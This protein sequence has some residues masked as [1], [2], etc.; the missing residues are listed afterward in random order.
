[1][2]KMYQKYAMTVTL[3][4]AM[5]FAL[6]ACGTSSASVVDSDAGD[7]AETNSIL[8]ENEQKVVMGEIA[9]IIGN[10]VTLKVVEMPQRQ[11]P[12]G[13]PEGEAPGNFGDMTEEE[14]QAMREQMGGDRQGGNF[15]DMTEEERQAMREQMGE[16]M[17]GRPGG[18]FADMTEEE[19]QA[20]IQEMFPD[21]VPEG[22]Q[23][24]E[25]DRFGQNYTG[26]ELD[27]IIPVGAPIL[28]ASFSFEGSEEAEIKLENLKA[29]DML[30]VTYASDDKTVEKVVRQTFTNMGGWRD[31]RG[32]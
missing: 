28:E 12:E 1:M 6:T 20:A 4:L 5:I 10:M 8:G 22:M 21:G 23:G 9:E 29:G 26:E 27:I 17:G 11:R 30:T 7:A 31:E 24:R 32:D 25:G 14:R 3:V 13:M 15:G 19:R 18:N 2:Y 16:Q